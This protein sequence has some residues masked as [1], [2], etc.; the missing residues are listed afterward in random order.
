MNEFIQKKLAIGTVNVHKVEPGLNTTSTSEVLREMSP[1]T[2]ELDF[3]FDY[4]KCANCGRNIEYSCYVLMHHTSAEKMSFCCRQCLLSKKNDVDIDDFDLYEISKCA[5]YDC[6]SELG[7]L[8]NMCVRKSKKNQKESISEL[9]CPHNFCDPAAAGQIRASFKLLKFIEKADAVSTKLNNESLKIAK[10]SKIL[11]LIMLG[12]TVITIFLTVLN[13][14]IVKQDSSNKLLRNIHEDL[15][16]TN[17]NVRGVGIGESLKKIDERLENVEKSNEL[18]M[19][20]RLI[21]DSLN[22]NVKSI[23]MF[24]RREKR[25]K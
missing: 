24:T 15:K 4:E 8:R 18:I 11:S 22:Q 20:L 6:C 17:Y 21:T 25:R 16:E 2:E 1:E 23:K 3:N 19:D 13:L 7:N 9:I 14:C 10:Q 5:S 12:L